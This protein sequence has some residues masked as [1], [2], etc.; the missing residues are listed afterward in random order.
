[1]KGNH[2]RRLRN[3]RIS[4]DIQLIHEVGRI[5]RKYTRRLRDAVVSE[6]NNDQNLV[7]SSSQETAVS[8]SSVAIQTENE[9]C[10][11]QE[12]KRSV[13]R[14]K[15]SFRRHHRVVEKDESP[16]SVNMDTS[17]NDKVEK[18]HD[19]VNSSINNVENTPNC[20]DTST[21]NNKAEK[22]CDCSAKYEKALQDLRNSLEEEH[23]KDKSKALQ[24]LSEKEN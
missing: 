12:R 10:S 6:D 15:G 20:V 23:K 5:K 17:T 22:T 18:T 21:N 19:C 9:T 14:P 16:P 4:E 3:S 7:S 1:M 2:Q 8:Y 24:E 11:K 13:G